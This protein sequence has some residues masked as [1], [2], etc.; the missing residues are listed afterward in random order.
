MLYLIQTNNNWP[1][2]LLAL[3]LGL[4]VG[5]WM[6]ARRRHR[7]TLAEPG[8]AVVQRTLAR[9]AAAVVP[10]AAAP[11]IEPVIPPAPPAA[12]MGASPFLAAPE[13]PA[14][15]LLLI[16]GVGPKLNALLISLG[17]H[18]FRQIAGWTEADVAEVDARL[19]TFK[20]RITRDRWQDQARLLAEGKMEEFARLYGTPGS[21]N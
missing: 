8:D 11:A 6:W 18:H 14:D 10:Q 19:G 17:V 4:L 13:G 12:A 15:D 21:E 3:M 20:G 7:V 2:F 9:E 5:A 1:Y 16:K